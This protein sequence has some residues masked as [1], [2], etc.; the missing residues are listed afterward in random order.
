MSLDAIKYVKIKA[1]Q[2]DNELIYATDLNVL[3]LI[4][5]LSTCK[6]CNKAA[7]HDKTF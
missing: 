3:Y 6:F 5:A 1:I 2:V 4:M 7:Q